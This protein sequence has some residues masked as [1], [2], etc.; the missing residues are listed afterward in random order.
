[1]T[2]DQELRLLEYINGL[3]GKPFE[4]GK[5]DCPLLAA[6]VLDCM[7]GGTRRSNMTGLW[8]DKKSAWRYMA[9]HGDFA[10][11]LKANGC[12]EINGGM[13]YAQP[14][15]LILMERTLAHDKRWHS[16]GVCLGAKAALMT[17]DDGLIRVPVFQIPPSTKVMRWPSQQ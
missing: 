16:V 11:H 7:D 8:H 6:G 10:E 12:D 14:G 17:E 1:M 5:N 3:V 15:D 13:I 9:K 4:Y 2:P